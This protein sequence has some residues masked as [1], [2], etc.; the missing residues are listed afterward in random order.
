[1]ISLQ[2]EKFKNDLERS[3]NEKSQFSKQNQMMT[4]ILK[5]AK[6]K[7]SRQLPPQIAQSKSDK[8]SESS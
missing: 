8:N 3:M 4:E 1:M 6:L 2:N 7:E 5:F